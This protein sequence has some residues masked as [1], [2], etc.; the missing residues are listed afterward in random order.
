MVSLFFVSISK[1]IIRL[2]ILISVGILHSP[3]D[4]NK[5]SEIF[6]K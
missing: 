5:V 2:K 6:I 1:N 4:Y 3:F